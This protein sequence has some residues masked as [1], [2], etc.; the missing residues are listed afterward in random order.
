MDISFLIDKAKDLPL[1]DALNF[2]VKSGITLTI[3]KK[4]KALMSFIRTKQNEGKYGFIPNK[5]E[6]E[7]LKKTKEKELYKE[8]C[9]LVSNKNY[10]DLIRTGYLISTLN[11]I[12]G[13]E[14]K[15]RI[16]EIKDIIV[17]NPNGAINIRICSIVT[18]GAITAVIDYLKSLKRK[19]YN[20]TYI[21]D[22]FNQ[23]I[24]EWLK[25]TIFTKK[26]DTQEKIKNEIVLKGEQKL[27][28]IMIFAMDSAREN[29]CLAV[30]EI[31]KD[32]LMDSYFHNSHNDE[33]GIH[34]VHVT[35]FTLLD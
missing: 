13:E 18:T 19:N 11:R 17:S 15:K 33:E 10:C 28:L 7:I 22:A 27:Q 24:Y 9:E 5:K 29:T 34:K 21:D 16:N 12:A 6:G 4:T 31:L 30:A 25:H 3:L 14:A 8:F 35:N 32:S 26:E 23:I 20:Q 1:P 2:F